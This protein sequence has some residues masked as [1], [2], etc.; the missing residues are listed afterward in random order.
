M[1][2]G[3]KVCQGQ[4]IGYVG[5]TGLATGPHLDFRVFKNGKPINPL[6]IESSPAS[7]VSKEHLAE[8]KAVA[9]QLMAKLDG[10]NIPKAQI[11]GV[12]ETVHRQGRFNP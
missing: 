8:F 1:K 6:K 9:S 4:V 12:S 2:K 5:S 3:G 10:Q 11:A 7:P